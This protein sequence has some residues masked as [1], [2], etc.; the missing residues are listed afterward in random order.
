ILKQFETGTSRRRVGI[1]PEGRAP[2]RENAPLFA[3]ATSGEQ[4][5]VVTSG[6]FGPSVNGPVAMGYVPAALAAD[7]TQL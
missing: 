5:G 7:G 2:V 1:K 3:D 6:G 4:I